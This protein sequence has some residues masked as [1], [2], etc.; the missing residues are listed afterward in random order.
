MALDGCDPYGRGKWGVDFNHRYGLASL[1]E[2]RITHSK[3]KIMLSTPACHRCS[4]HAH[5]HRRNCPY[6]KP[7]DAEILRRLQAEHDHGLKKHETQVARK[8]LLEQLD[9]ATEALRAQA[10][11]VGVKTTQQAIERIRQKVD[12]IYPMPEEWNHDQDRT[13]DSRQDHGV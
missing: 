11:Q 4:G 6:W 8:H 2:N 12:E 13:E 5:G 10:D 3:G 7:E 9:K 1:D